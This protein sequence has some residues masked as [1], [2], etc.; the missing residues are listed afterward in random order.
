MCEKKC[1]QNSIVHYLLAIH[2]FDLM[3]FIIGRLIMIALDK[4]VLF[5]IISM[6]FI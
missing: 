4:R 3:F 2:D 6:N 1:G 5:F